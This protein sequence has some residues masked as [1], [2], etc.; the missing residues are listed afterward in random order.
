MTPKGITRLPNGRYRVR[1]KRGN[2]WHSGGQHDDHADAQRAL[3]D[4]LERVGPRAPTRVP[5]KP[6]PNQTY[7]ER[8][9]YPCHCGYQVRCTRGGVIHYGGTFR[10]LD[11][12]L[13]AR[14]EIEGSNPSK[15]TKKTQQP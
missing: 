2:T 8:N 3:N 14:D 4:L 10:T 13:A 1:T 5:S 7:G 9:I 15:K 12:A 11:E 6:I